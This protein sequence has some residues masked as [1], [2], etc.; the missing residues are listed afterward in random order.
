M[1]SEKRAQAATLERQGMNCI[2]KVLLLAGGLAVAVTLLNYALGFGWFSL[3]AGLPT[4][5]AISV[6]VP[7]FLGVHD[8]TLAVARRLREGKR[9]RNPRKRMS[10]PVPAVAIAARAPVAE[11]GGRAIATLPAAPL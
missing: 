2:H 11:R 1:A 8:R 7:F 4:F 5:V 6:L 3:I 9:R 10:R